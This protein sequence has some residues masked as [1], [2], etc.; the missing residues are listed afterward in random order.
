PR[1]GVTIRRRAGVS[2]RPRQDPAGPQ[3]AQ[4]SRSHTTTCP[5]SPPATQVKPSGGNATPPIVPIFQSQPLPGA[6]LSA[7]QKRTVPSL[8]PVAIVLPSQL[9]ATAVTGPVCP[10]REIR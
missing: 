8:P 9:Y 1:S 3:R 2:T 5:L 4:S 7:S 6:P 10:R